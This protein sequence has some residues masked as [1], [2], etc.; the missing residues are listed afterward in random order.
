MD[1]TEETI[2]P[3]AEPSQAAP[4][5]TLAPSSQPD[6]EAKSS[7]ADGAK[8]P[9]T[10]S[11]ALKDVKLEGVEEVAGDEP[12]KTEAPPA[13]ETAKPGE[14]PAVGPAKKDEPGKTPEHPIDSADV[15]FQKRPEWQEAIKLG[16]DKIK[17]ILRKLMG[18]EVAL[19]QTV[20]ELEP[21]REVV[22]ELRT[23]TGDEQGF[24]TMR[25]IVKLYATEPDK[26]VPILESMLKDARQRAG[27]EIVSTD[28]QQRLDAVKQAVKRGDL[29]T[30]DGQQRETELLELEQARVTRKNAE[31]KLQQTE[32]RRQRSEADAQTNAVVSALNSWE[33]N[34]RERDPDFGVVTTLDD[35]KH[36]ESIADQV[37]DAISLKDQHTKATKHRAPTS[38]ELVS[39]AARIYKLARGRLG[40]PTLREQRP[41]T[42]QGSSLTAKPKARTLREAMDQVRLD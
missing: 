22:K 42:A 23:H 2:K 36:G 37:F 30:E 13:E 39:E 26:S 38:E 40:T 10:V 33:E 19:T 9:Q 12:A 21:M 1:T 41:I 7:T 29:T 27:M 24:S 34:I 3:A 16:G 8:A 32:A 20:R 4:D 18:R 11:D 28:L 25:N 31:T 35:P 15:P 14:E 6:V 5:A 17:P